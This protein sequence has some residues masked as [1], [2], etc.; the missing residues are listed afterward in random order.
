[1]SRGSDGYIAQVNTNVGLA[2]SCIAMKYHFG[3]WPSLYR[4]HCTYDDPNLL[5][6]R[7]EPSQ[8]ST[9]VRRPSKTYIKEAHG[10]HL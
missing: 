4:R 9:H 10:A 2:I 8:L 6:R 7:L 1:M 3:N 5:D